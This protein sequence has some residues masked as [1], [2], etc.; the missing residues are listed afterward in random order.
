M[1]TMPI[2]RARMMHGV[3]SQL[4]YRDEYE[5]DRMTSKNLAMAVV[6]LVCGSGTDSDGSAD[7]EAQCGSDRTGNAAMHALEKDLVEP[8]LHQEEA[9]KASGKYAA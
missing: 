6:M 8:Q 4:A 7:A 3:E 5:K 9:A 2:P 1:M